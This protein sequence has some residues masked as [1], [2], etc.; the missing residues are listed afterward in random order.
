MGRAAGAQASRAAGNCAGQRAGRD[1]APAPVNEPQLFFG[2]V[3]ELVREKLRYTYA[4]R[5]GPKGSNRW[6]ANWWMYP[7]AISRL[8]VLW[9]AWEALRLEPTFG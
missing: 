5:V 2:S 8:D 9:R 1:R 7:E 3:D 6:D 4:R